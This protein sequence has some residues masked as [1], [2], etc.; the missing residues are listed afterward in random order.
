MTAD[1][2]WFLRRLQLLFRQAPSGSRTVLAAK[3]VVV[4]ADGGA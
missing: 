3:N 4:D 1:K 2:R